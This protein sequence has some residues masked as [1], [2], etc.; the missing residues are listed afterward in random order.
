MIG[1]FFFFF[2][3]FLQPNA[4]I[5]GGGDV[6]QERKSRQSIAPV[7]RNQF[8]N[9]PLTDWSD[10]DDHWM[11]LIEETDDLFDRVESVLA[12]PSVPPGD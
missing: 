2:F 3:F 12:E 5:T 6:D 10:I 11:E 8:N 7:A 4:P 9:E 1:A